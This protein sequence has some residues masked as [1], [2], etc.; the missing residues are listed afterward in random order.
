MTQHDKNTK[1][2]RV[3]SL[4]AVVQQKIEVAPGLCIFRIAPKGWELPPFR[5]GQYTV[6]GLPPG[7]KRVIYSQPPLR[8]V[9]RD[10]LIKRPYSIASS[11]SHKHYLEFYIKMV[12]NGALTPRLFAL[13]NGGKVWMREKVFGMFTLDDFPVEK[14]VIF[15]ATGTGLAP[16]MSMLR[17]HLISDTGRKWAV[18]HGA[19]NSWDLGY[20]DEL[21]TMERFCPAFTYIPM[22]SD[23]QNEPVPWTG[24]VG[25]LDKAWKEAY[26]Q[27]AWK[28]DVNAE[29]TVIFLCGHPMMVEGMEKLLTG[30]GFVPHSRREPGNLVREKFS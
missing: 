29:N 26:V 6:L 1:E 19:L 7:A 20:R 2:V 23:P 30:E 16:Y 27:K 15:F 5:P 9:P 18:V 10:L 3:E 11:S 13:K 17:S 8:P 4:N 21:L 25:F 28:E 24:H 12:S 14:N 22:I